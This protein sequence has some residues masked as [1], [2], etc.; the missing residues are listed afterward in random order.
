MGGKTMGSKKRPVYLTSIIDEE[1]DEIHD[2]FLTEKGIQMF[3]KMINANPEDNINIRCDL[4]DEVG[5]ETATYLS[6]LAKEPD[7]QFLIDICFKDMDIGIV[8]DKFNNLVKQ[9]YITAINKGGVPKLTDKGLER[10][11]VE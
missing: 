11:K 9:G 8:H 3:N 2:I 10:V 1:K 5:F 4:I 7:N 6:W